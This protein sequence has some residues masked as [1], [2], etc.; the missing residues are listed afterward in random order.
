VTPWGG[1]VR[2]RIEVEVGRAGGGEEEGWSVGPFGKVRG[3]FD[4]LRTA[5]SLCPRKVRVNEDVG[6]DVVQMVG[7][8][9]EMALGDVGGN[10]SYAAK[11]TR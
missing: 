3:T 10:A 6:E 8:W 11:F 9:R 7:F 5:F 4:V 2:E 1:D